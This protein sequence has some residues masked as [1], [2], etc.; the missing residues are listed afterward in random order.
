[1]TNRKIMAVMLVL[2]AAGC[3]SKEEA[4][5]VETPQPKAPVVSDTEKVTEQEKRF[6]IARH[7]V[8]RSTAKRWE[9]F[10]VV[11]DLAVGGFEPAR[12]Y[13]LSVRDTKPVLPGES[14]ATFG[15]Y[16]DAV[17]SMLTAVSYKLRTDKGKDCSASHNFALTDTKHGTGPGLEQWMF[18][19]C[20]EKVIVPVQLR[21]NQE[22][23]RIDA[24]VAPEG[25]AIQ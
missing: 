11:M 25:I 14:E 2:A 10:R 9:G 24:E 1:M 13:Y 17:K 20:E 12:E 19:Y 22:T 8:E 3:S 18:D 15:T 23:G 6:F 21:L 4:K 5:P 16:A 7:A